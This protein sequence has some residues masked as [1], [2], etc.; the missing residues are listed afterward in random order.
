[1]GVAEIIS[2]GPDGL[3]TAQIVF[4]VGG[5]STAIAAIDAELVQ[6]EEELELIEEEITQAEV[7]LA[8]KQ[9]EC[10]DLSAAYAKIG[11]ETILAAQESLEQI[12]EAWEEYTHG[13]NDGLSYTIRGGGLSFGFPEAFDEEDLEEPLEEEELPEIA[14][15]LHQQKVNWNTAAGKKWVSASGSSPTPVPKEGSA[16][17]AYLEWMRCAIEQWAL[18]MYLT[19]VERFRDVRLY[20]KSSLE[21]R[22]LQIQEAV[23]NGESRSMWCADLTTDLIGDVDTIE[24]DGAP[25]TIL[26][27]PG[28][29]ANIVDDGGSPGYLSNIMAQT[30]AQTG[31]AWALLPG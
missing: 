11:E 23:A 15:T 27:G 22:K 17:E 13:G 3:Y 5:A 10:Y 4:D 21:L 6:I 28:G 20:R 8:S 30:P 14:Y 2:G 26:I 7:N 19:S 12:K 24:I 29:D 31:L 1:M 9:T 25:T 16:E 18:Q